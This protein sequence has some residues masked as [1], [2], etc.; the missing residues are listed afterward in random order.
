MSINESTK[1]SFIDVLIS[2]RGLQ[3]L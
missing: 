3:S 1:E 2:R